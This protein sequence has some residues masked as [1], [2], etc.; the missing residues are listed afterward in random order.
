LQTRDGLAERFPASLAVGGLKLR[1]LQPAE[2]R[3]RP[4]SGRAGSFL[5]VPLGEQRGDG[6]RLFAS[7]N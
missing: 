1:E 4:N 7:E 6:V 5:D 2:E 3:S